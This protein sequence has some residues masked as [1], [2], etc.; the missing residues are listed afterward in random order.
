MDMTA[1]IDANAVRIQQIGGER[2]AALQYHCATTEQ[3]P[4]LGGGVSTGQKLRPMEPNR[5]NLI[6]NRH[7]YVSAIDATSALAVETRVKDQD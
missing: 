4:I 2:I 3:P 7:R 5:L 6:D 1:L